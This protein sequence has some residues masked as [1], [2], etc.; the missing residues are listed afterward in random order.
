MTAEIGQL[1][2]TLALALSLVLSVT[3]LSGARVTAG[4]S[5]RIASSAAM[6]L[7]VFIVLAFGALEYASRKA[8]LFEIRK[9]II[10]EVTERGFP[11]RLGMEELRGLVR[12]HRLIAMD[13]VDLAESNFI[14]LSRQPLPIIKL[15]R[16][17]VDQLTRSDGTRLRQISAFVRLQNHYV[18]AEG[19]E[20]PEQERLLKD[21]GVQYAQGWLYSKSV[22]AEDFQA[23]YAAHA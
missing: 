21:A 6:G 22:S 14:V 15:D 2:L 9:Q 12:E 13:D 7:L 5:R 20:T 3:G 23:F 4:V 19:V 11:D 1:S 18:V 8:H 10:L 17:F 16:D